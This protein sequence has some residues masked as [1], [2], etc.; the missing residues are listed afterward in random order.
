MNF[1]IVSFI[2]DILIFIFWTGIVYYIGLKA[3]KE[4]FIKEM[5][6]LSSRLNDMSKEL[7]NKNKD[8]K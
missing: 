8:E 5:Q 2:K 6:S 7:L 3:G 4:A 1:D